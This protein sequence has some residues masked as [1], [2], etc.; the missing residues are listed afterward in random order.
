VPTRGRPP[1]RRVALLTATYVLVHAAWLATHWGGAG[2]RVLI[3]DLF[4]L[5]TFL[6]TGLAALRTARHPNLDARIRRTWGALAASFVVLWL[7][8]AAWTWSDLVPGAPTAA[9]GTWAHRLVLVSYAP[10]LLGLLGLPSAPR[11]RSHRRRFALDVATTVLGAGLVLWCVVVRP[12]AAP[13]GESV[14]ALASFDTALLDLTVV[15]VLVASLLGRMDNGSRLAL[16]LLASG[17]LL[18]I[19]GGVV[20]ALLHRA[21]PITPGHWVDG[22][23]MVSDALLLLA[24]DVQ[25][26]HAADGT[27]SAGAPKESADGGFSVLPYLGAALASGVLLLVSRPWWGGSLGVAVW[28][29]VALTALVAV[30]QAGAVRDN[31]RLTA[32]RIAQEEYFRALIEHAS[33]LVFVA[34]PDGDLRYASPAAER[35]LGLAHGAPVGRPLWELLHP[36]DVE[37]AR[38]ALAAA[39]QGTRTV[40]ELRAGHG[41]ASQSGASNGGAWRTVEAVVGRLPGAT[42]QAVLNVRDVTDRVTSAAE[43]RESRRALET[44]FGNL[45]GMA[46]RCLNTP[47]WPL[48]LASD[49]CRALTGYAADDL[50]TRNGQPPRVAYGSLVHPDDRD[51]VW[52]TVQ[53]AMAR[54]EPFQIHYRITA[55]DGTERQVWEQGRAVADERGEIRALEGF[56]MDVTER[57]RLVAQRDAERALLDAV[58]EQMPAA[59][60]IAEAPSGRLLVG[61]SVVDRMFDGALSNEGALLDATSLVGFHPDGRPVAADEWPF[62]R[63][64]R[65]EQVLGEELRVPRDG[66]DAWVRF[67]AGPVHDRDGRI[68]AG[69]AVAEDVSAQKQL[70]SRLEHQAFHDPLTGL[71]NR[72]LFR[73]RVAQALAQS[74]RT[75][76]RPTVLFLDLDDFKAVNDSLGHVE[77]DRL[78]VEVGGRL[79]AATRGCD[80]V[81]RLGGDEFAVLLS[82]AA[83]PEEATIV[84]DRILGAFARP[85]ALGAHTVRVG[86]SVGIAS[87]SPDDGAD[88]LL[89]NADLAMYRAKARGKGVYEVFSAE[90]YEAM[91]ERVALEGDLRL[92]LERDEFRLVYQPI[93]DLA[94]ERV[95]G[96][97][98]L[99][100]WHHAERGVVPPARF[101]GIAESSGLILPLGRWVLDQACAQAAAWR[102]RGAD[103]L[104]VAVNISGRQLQDPAFVGDVAAALAR[105]ELAPE[106][107]LLEITEGVVMHDIEA[108]LERL[109]ALKALG[110]RVAIDDF[111]TG[112][113]S[114]A[115]LQRF[116]VDVL[117]IDKSFVD[118]VHERDSDEAL[119]RTIV[120]MGRTLSL[121]TV[122]EGVEHAAQRDTLRALGCT[123]AQ[124]YLFSRP[125]APADLEPLLTAQ[126]AER[127]A[128]SV[129]A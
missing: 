18:S 84:A 103:D 34:G 104:Y 111:G 39:L 28:G 49:G 55:A 19:A 116:P 83:R 91:H 50:C 70:E 101:I 42:A 127:R 41:D 74:Q 11:S 81:A 35:A 105:A 47:D 10:L 57:E 4:L 20:V 69:V 65:G 21:G 26:R 40:V 68:I 30:R 14:A 122:A 58:L 46:Y 25:Y 85:V 96:V 123:L 33:D 66:N 108:N 54:R 88:E 27:P 120:S 78:L 1:R 8:N 3:A 12:D 43:L 118:G 73:D 59:V 38:E 15:A 76:A 93:V 114:L 22:V 128:Q 72:A 106:A 98:A 53:T 51:R 5:P 32:E 100:R 89:R 44:L 112:Y 80:T 121:C 129:L 113:S 56:V 6:F 109:A 23:W 77:G 60:V 36:D 71:A 29:S 110:V 24:A 75:G 95:V 9:L 115:Y 67:R 37:R 119:A 90:M 126:S 48:E 52:E 86:S 97:E 87:A 99:A 94:T 16:R 107:L 62:V 13:A 125:A 124:G 63:A 2:R 102:R 61:N 82:V 92:A 79:L 31:R 17:E 45:P 64:V 117:K 7:A